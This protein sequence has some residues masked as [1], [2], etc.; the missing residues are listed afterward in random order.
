M[1]TFRSALEKTKLAPEYS[2]IIADQTIELGPCGMGAP[3][4]ESS[5][6]LKTMEPGQVLMTESE[7]P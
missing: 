4:L 7:H 3:V 6:T 5:W 1:S 2:H